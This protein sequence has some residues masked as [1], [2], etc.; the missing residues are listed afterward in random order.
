MEHMFE[1][2]G[3]MQ[4]MDGCIDCHGECKGSCAGTCYGS[5][6]RSTWPVH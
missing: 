6:P 1:L 3:F 5:G 4:D 2:N